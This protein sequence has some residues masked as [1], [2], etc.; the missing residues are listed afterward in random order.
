MQTTHARI[1][2]KVDIRKSRRV[3]FRILPVEKRVFYHG[4]TKPAVNVS[5]RHA[6]V[7]LREHVSRHHNVGPHLKA[8][9][10]GSRILAQRH[11][12]GCGNMCVFKQQ[13]KRLGGIA[14]CLM[15]SCLLKR[16]RYVRWQNVRKLRDI[17]FQR[18]FNRFRG[19][20]FHVFLTPLA[21]FLRLHPRCLPSQQS[22]TW[23]FS[24]LSSL[25]RFF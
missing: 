24:L 7:D 14:V 2:H 18:A 10:R 16:L 13:V 9:P 1:I 21:R 5:T 3:V 6:F 20:D 11:A 23:S 22:S 4:L 15:L 19:N 17:L 8:D 12:I 25:R